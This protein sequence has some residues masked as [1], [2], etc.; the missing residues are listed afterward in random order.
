MS[1]RFREHSHSK[2]NYYLG[3]RTDWRASSV[4]VA[5]SWPT[6]VVAEAVVHVEVCFDSRDLARQHNA[7]N[8]L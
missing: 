6:L 2:L 3:M 1:E 7:L 5:A 4:V 8:V